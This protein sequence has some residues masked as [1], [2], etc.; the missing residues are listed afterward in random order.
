MMPNPPYEGQGGGFAPGTWNKESV[1][2]ISLDPENL[3]N[4]Q[5]DHKE[6]DF[7]LPFSTQFFDMRIKGINSCQ[8]NEEFVINE[9]AQNILK[10]NV[11]ILFEIL[12]LNPAMI[13]E[14]DPRLNS[15][16]LYPICW[17]YLR[18]CGSAHI[19]LTKSRLQL[20][21]YKYWHN[22]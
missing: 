1:A 6:V 12:E 3:N 5:F 13:A 9:F 21:K 2:T 7:I 8:W 17:A 10:P 18:P 11:V 20:Y 15:D 16:N 4:A 22:K 14:R 19:H